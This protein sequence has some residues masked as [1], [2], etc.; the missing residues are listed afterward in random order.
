MQ[1]SPWHQEMH[2]PEER[3]SLKTLLPNLLK[4]RAS[5]PQ[6]LLKLQLSNLHNRS[7]KA[8]LQMEQE[9]MSSHSLNSR[10]FSNSRDQLSLPQDQCSSLFS[11]RFSSMSRFLCSSRFSNLCSNMSRFLCSKPDQ[12]LQS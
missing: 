5:Q 2:R 6:L 8:M 10:W 12:L 3:P 9:P 4:R 7:Q 11:S 1:T